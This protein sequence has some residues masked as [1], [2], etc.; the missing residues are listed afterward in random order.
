MKRFLIFLIFYGINFLYAQI[1]IGTTTPHISSKLEISS[2]SQGFLPPRMTTAQRN[3]IISPAEGLSIYNT[4]AKCL[5]FYD[6]TAWKSNCSSASTS[7]FAGNLLYPDGVDF[8]NVFV[9]HLL[10]SQSYTVPAGKNLYLFIYG[11]NATINGV[12]ILSGSSLNYG[13]VQNQPFI[14]GSGQTLVNSGV[15]GTIYLNGF[16]CDATVTA[17]TA[18]ATTTNPYY[19]VPTGKTLV[20]LNTYIATPN[21]ANGGIYILASPNVNN[22]S[23]GIFQNIILGLPMIAPEGSLVFSST[24]ANGLV[25]FNGYLK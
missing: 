17:V 21:V 7:K 23:A 5:E 3:A 15:T 18:V 2:T 22:I 24:A 12:S 25:T 8:S 10:P 4:D 14:V 13:S 1:G 9:K 16:L 11:N 20:I 6:G 19:T